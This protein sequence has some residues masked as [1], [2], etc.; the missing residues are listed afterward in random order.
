MDHTE[1]TM[2][3]IHSNS[4]TLSLPGYPRLDQQYSHGTDHGPRPSM[5]GGA[6][7]LMIVRNV[8][9]APP[10]SGCYLFTGLEGVLQLQGTIE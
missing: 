7:E 6:P 5:T 9:P 8:V 1:C 10:H 2:A 4:M 3:M